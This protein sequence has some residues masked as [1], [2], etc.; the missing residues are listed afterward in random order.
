MSDTPALPRKPR[1]DEMD[2]YGLSHPGKVR[3]ENQDHFLMATFHKRINVIAT[4]LPDA[5]R[6]LPV[7]EQR[8]AYVAMVADGVGGGVGGAETVPRRCRR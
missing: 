5:E 7:G 3:R 2:V 8:L 1:D 6:R 4:N